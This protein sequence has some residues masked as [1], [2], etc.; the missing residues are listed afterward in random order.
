MK[1]KPIKRKSRRI[2]PLS[3]VEK[4]SS[5]NS[6]ETEPDRCALY[7]GIPIYEAH[8]Y[9]YDDLF[10]SFVIVNIECLDIMRQHLRDFYFYYTRDVNHELEIREIDAK[11]K[12][13]RGKDFKFTTKDLQDKLLALSPLVKD[14]MAL[15]E[16][17]KLVKDFQ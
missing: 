14:A 5:G 8:K 4:V 17:I 15:E 13:H 3:I 6:A 12:R 11:L 10:K 1:V 7:Y 9:D 2:S 16:M